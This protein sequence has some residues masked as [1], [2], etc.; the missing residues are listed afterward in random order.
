VRR[1]VVGREQAG[2]AAGVEFDRCRPVGDDGHQ[3]DR[4]PQPAVTG[5]RDR[6]PPELEDV[7][8][9]TG[10]QDRDRHV[11]T[12]PF[13]RGRERRGLASRVVADQHERTRLRTCPCEVAVP[14][15][16]GCAVET[17]RLA[18]PHAEHTIALESRADRRHLAPEHGGRRELLVEPGLMHDCVLSEQRRVSAQFPIQATQRRARVA[19]H[20]SRRVETGGMVEAH[21]IDEQPDDRRNP[22]DEVASPLRSV[23]IFERDH[24]IVRG[25]A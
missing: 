2:G 6:V 4:S 18:V 21:L 1:V 25:P 15:G 5:E 24:L 19:R 9:A 22:A 20:E 17:W 3:L 14:D 23:P 13:R 12:D 16:V 7:L 11:G 10:V 8:N